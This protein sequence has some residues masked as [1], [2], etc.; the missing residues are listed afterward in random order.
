MVSACRKNGAIPFLW[1]NG[2]AVGGG[3]EHF[4]LFNRKDGMKQADT[5]AIPAIMRGTQT[6][7]PWK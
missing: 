3:Q 1:D 7:T 2:A 5:I 4:G 6:P